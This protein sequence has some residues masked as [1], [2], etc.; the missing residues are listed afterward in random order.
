MAHLITRRLEDVFFPCVQD[1]EEENQLLEIT[2]MF[3]PK[4]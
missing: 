1:Q 4:V 2:S 3:T